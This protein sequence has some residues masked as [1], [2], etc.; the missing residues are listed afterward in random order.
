MGV[1]MG[2]GAAGEC[3][4]RTQEKDAGGGWGAGCRR[5]RA[6]TQEEDMGG[7]RGQLLPRAWKGLSDCCTQ[8]SLLPEALLS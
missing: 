2:E 3:R 7:G 5:R 8:P 4:K 6:R 1:D